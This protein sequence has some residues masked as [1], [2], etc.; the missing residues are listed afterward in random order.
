MNLSAQWPI[1]VLRTVEDLFHA[2]EDM[3][4]RRWVSR[5]QNCAYGVVV[6]SIDRGE[7]AAVSRSQK[8]K[9]EREG[10][11]RFRSAARHFLPG[12]E[13]AVVDDFV[14][15]AVL[16]HHGVPTRLVDWTTEPEIAAFFSIWNNV[17]SDGEIW[18]FDN[19]A[20]ETK[21][22]AQW[23]R[24]LNTTVDGSGNDDKFAAGATAFAEDPPPWIAMM[25]YRHGMPRQIAQSSCYSLMAC[26]GIDHATALGTLLGDPTLFRRYVVKAEVKESALEVLAERGKSEATLFPD[27]AG[28]ARYA[29]CVFQV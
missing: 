13:T 23:K 21:G 3:R 9:L 28:A 29:G 16:R 4:A 17:K 25:D 1:Q 6:P 24:W 18:A 14:A 12:E 15:L 26:F 20:Y 22:K 8:L 11:I 2:L 5:G 7:L 10:I 27:S 19:A